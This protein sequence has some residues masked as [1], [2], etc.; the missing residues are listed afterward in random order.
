MINLQLKSQS[1]STQDLRVLRESPSYSLPQLIDLTEERS[2][3]NTRLP[4]MKKYLTMKSRFLK[5][6]SPFLLLVPFLLALFPYLLITGTSAIQSTWLLLFLFPFTII[7]VLFIDFSLWN[8]FEGKKRFFIW[9]IEL[10]LS[11][12][13]VYFLI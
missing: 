8:F 5:R 2:S 12:V 6:L 4:L 9:L 7:N 10:T 3:V 1:A 11:F 13:I